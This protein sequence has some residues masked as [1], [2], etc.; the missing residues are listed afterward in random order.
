MS[1]F[2][3]VLHAFI[4]CNMH[5]CV[6]GAFGAILLCRSLLANRNHKQDVAREDMVIGLVHIILAML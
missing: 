6:Y 2:E 4:N 3:I 5:L 1:A